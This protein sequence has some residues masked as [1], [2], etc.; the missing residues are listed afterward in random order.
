MAKTYCKKCGSVL[1][2]DAEFCGKCETK[3]SLASKVENPKTKIHEALSNNTQKSVHPKIIN[4]N[5]PT[6]KQ[7]DFMVAAMLSLFL[8]VIGVDRFYLGK[9]GTGILKLITFGGF[10][11][12]YL[13]DL[14]MILTGKAKSH[15]RQ[16]LKNRQKNLSLA[17]IVTGLVF[18]AI[19]IN[20]FAATLYKP[21]TTVK[22]DGSTTDQP[23]II[24]TFGANSVNPI[25][26]T[27]APTPPAPK[28]YDGSGDDVVTI[29][30]PSDGS[31]IVLFE[32]PDCTR[33]TVVK[34]DGAESLLVNT[35]GSYTGSHLIDTRSGSNTTHII[36]TAVG[37][38]K[39]TV[40][41]LD[42]ATQQTAGQPISG[43]GDAVVHITGKT[44]KARITNTGESNFTIHIYP[45]NGNSANLAINTIGSYKGTVP[46]EAPAY[47]QVGSS[48]D[49]S[50]TPN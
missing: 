19:I 41:G 29:Q 9:I 8:G 17:L 7:K 4:K 50:I 35:I 12:W 43:I 1:L 26:P 20:I 32:C 47:V 39:L 44:S 22:V 15:D 46:L 49:W 25:T 36:V 30:K 10:G 14:I 27:P 45:E 33:N 6:L 2:K 16:K 42:Q 13:I 23:F 48:G 37:A 28:V 40:G 3:V 18:L 38:W 34:T 24:A 5:Q 21:T 11:I 31:A